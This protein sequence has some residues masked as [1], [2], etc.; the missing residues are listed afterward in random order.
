MKEIEINKFLSDLA[1]SNIID[2]YFVGYTFEECR[3]KAKLPF[4]FLIVKNN[5]I[6]IIE[7]DGRQH[8][9]PNCFWS[10]EEAVISACDLSA[11]SITS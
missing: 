7:F 1:N 11:A 6:G 4:D 3:D 5:K 8:F 2:E 10:L 9:V